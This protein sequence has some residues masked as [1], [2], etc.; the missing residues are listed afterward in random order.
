MSRAKFHSKAKTKFLRHALVVH[1]ADQ[2]RQEVPPEQ[3]SVVVPVAALRFGQ[4]L[5]D[6]MDK[7]DKIVRDYVDELRAGQP[8]QP[9]PRSCFYVTAAA[10]A[11]GVATD[12]VCRSPCCHCTGYREACCGASPSR[13]RLAAV[14]EILQPLAAGEHLH[15]Y[16]RA[17]RLLVL[18]QQPARDPSHLCTQA[19]RGRGC[20]RQ[21]SL[22]ERHH[23]FWSACRGLQGKACR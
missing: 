15:R 17:L 8:R 12:G 22:H 4:L 9:R 16:A 11:L 10:A 14:K 5:S 1:L 23:R 3:W 20:C 2:A 18:G 13:R 6:Y 21:P 7:V 19:R